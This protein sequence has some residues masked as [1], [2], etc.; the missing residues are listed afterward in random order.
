MRKPTCFKKLLPLA[1]LPFAILALT[2][3]AEAQSS[4]VTKRTDFNVIVHGWGFENTTRRVCENGDCRTE[5]AGIAAAFGLNPVAN[6]VFPWALC[7]GMSLSA[8]D[9]FREGRSI[10]GWSAEVKFELIRAQTNTITEATVLNFSTLSSRALLKQP[11]LSHA[12]RTSWPIVKRSIDN[13]APIILGLIYKRAWSPFE[14]FENHQ[15]L[16]IG[17]ETGLSNNQIRIIAYDPNYPGVESV[18]TFGP[19]DQ[20]S[21]HGNNEFLPISQ[22]TSYGG[23]EIKRCWWRECAESNKIYGFFP[24]PVGSGPRSAPNQS[25]INYLLLR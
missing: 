11:K 2:S 21:E 15:V 8:L 6:A 18:I 23:G 12:I 20:A 4:T 13:G 14:V 9:R 22:W 1:V 10:E 16:A 24:I 19:L 17:Y 25:A 3:V 5:N 7:G